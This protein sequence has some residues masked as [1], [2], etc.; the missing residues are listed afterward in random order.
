MKISDI[1]HFPVKSLSGNHLKSSEIHERGLKDDRR[2]MLIDESNTF[3]SQRKYPMLSQIDVGITEDNIVLRDRRTN[4]VIKQALQFELKK[5][6]VSIWRKNC[7]SHHFLK[8]D[9]DQWISEQIGA[10]LRFVYMDESDRRPI[11]QKYAQSEDEIV[12]FADGYP[13]L[14][15]N[16]ASLKDLN[17]HLR[18]PIS[19]EH[20]RPN[21]VIEHDI[22]W[23]EDH[24]KKLR[25]GEVLLRIPKPCE[26]CIV[27]DID[28]ITGKNKSSEVLQTLAKIRMPKGGIYFGL[29][30]IVEKTG[31]VRLGDKVEIV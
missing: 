3:V 5:T 4:F 20:F 9:L 13:I 24:W 19:M 6:E 18:D 14:I 17:D 2:I 22:A 31:K 11:N 1:I 15:A 30:A 21:L 26:R 10:P 29:N 7:T 16:T 12:S 27:I 25:I 23:D 8:P 28:P